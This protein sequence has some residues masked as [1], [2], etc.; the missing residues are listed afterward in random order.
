MSGIGDAPALLVGER[1]DF[2]ASGGVIALVIAD[3]K[4]RLHVS[5][6]AAAKRDLRISSKLAKLA[7]VVD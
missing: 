5:R 4:V 2:I 7:L 3:N 6:Q 1:T